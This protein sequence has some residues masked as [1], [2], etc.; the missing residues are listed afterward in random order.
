MLKNHP[1]MQFLV[2]DMNNADCPMPDIECKKCD[3]GQG[4]GWQGGTIVLC[5]G[6]WSDVSFF[7]ELRHAWQACLFKPRPKRPKKQ[8][9]SH[10]QQLSFV[11][12]KGAITDCQRQ[13]QREFDADFTA[14]CA[15]VTPPSA[16]CDCAEARCKE[17]GAVGRDCGDNAGN[18]CHALREQYEKGGKCK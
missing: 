17:N 14:N 9:P 7:H 16:P 11:R 8:T 3:P 12:F 15:N 4:G 2:D 13:A 18:T 10:Q 6:E 5:D 1:E